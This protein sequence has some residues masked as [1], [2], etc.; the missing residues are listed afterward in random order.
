MRR[1]DLVT[2]TSLLSVA[3]ASCGGG[4]SSPDAAALPDSPSGET[5]QASPFC[6]D[7]LPVSTVTDLTGTWVVRMVAAQ[8]VSAPIVGA[9]HVQNVFYLLYDV[10]QNGVEVTID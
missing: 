2:L 8:I 10:R 5:S 7:T 3:V 6:T 9:I 4:G 1:L